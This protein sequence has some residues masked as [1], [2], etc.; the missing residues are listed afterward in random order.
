[1]ES[2]S[3]MGSGYLMSSGK[4]TEEQARGT[5]NQIYSPHSFIRDS[6]GDNGEVRD[7]KTA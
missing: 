5:K 4:S 6:L 2:V 3:N 1:M 7:Q